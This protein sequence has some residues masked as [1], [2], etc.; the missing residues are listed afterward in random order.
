MIEVLTGKRETII[1]EK[2]IP[3]RMHLNTDAEDFPLHWQN[4]FEIVMPLEYGYS[5]SIE[6]KT[7]N[8][9]P[10][11]I[12]IISP[13]VLHSIVAPKQGARY[14][15]LINPTMFDSFAEGDSIRSCFYPYAIF[16]K[17]KN[18]HV[19][20]QLSD[21]LHN[22][23]Y[24]YS[25]NHSMKYI[26]LHGIIL[27]FMVLAGRNNIQCSYE[28]NPVITQGGHK[29]TELFHKICT[30]MIDHCTEDITPKELA[31]S[32]NFSTSHFIRLFRQVTGV[33]FHD[34]INQN[35]IAYAK[36]LL[37]THSDMTIMEI[38]LQSG[39][40]SLSTFNRTFKNV[41]KLTP[42]EYRNLQGN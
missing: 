27:N 4:S 14:I 28:E 39:F 31:L 6:D 2:N 20:Q 10:G 40:S 36:K 26:A 33:S 5:F 16:N 22:I 23:W 18:S 42:S 41:T 35:R 12:I 29:Y 11:D 38:S 37:Y 7:E 1:Y 21:I 13:G 9:T 8:L 24:E 25:S 15:L 30:Y 34:F 17:D 3:L 32:N 19:K